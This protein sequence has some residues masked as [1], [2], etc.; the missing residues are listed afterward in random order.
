MYTGK[1]LVYRERLKLKGRGRII[2][3]TKEVRGQ[4]MD[5]ETLE[6]ICLEKRSPFPLSL[7]ERGEGR[8][9]ER[10]LLGGELKRASTCPVN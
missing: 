3:V 5:L 1:E 9:G 7:E 8:G 6:G 4:G 10:T 2:N